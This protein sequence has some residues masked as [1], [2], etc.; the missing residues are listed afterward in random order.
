MNTARA[1]DVNS[2]QL[3]T[4]LLIA[5]QGSAFKEELTENI[6]NQ[7]KSRPI[8]IKIIDLT[9]LPSIDG[10]D[11]DA[12]VIIHAWEYF[13]PQENVKKFIDKTEDRNK[14]VVVTTSGEGH[15]TLEGIDG[16]SSASTSSEIDFVTSQVLVRIE[17]ILE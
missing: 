10:N 2:P 5:T 6:V 1:Y 7:F 12:A 17:K 16:I 15:S 8:Y 4:K 13:M 3:E 9:D 14:L 11:W